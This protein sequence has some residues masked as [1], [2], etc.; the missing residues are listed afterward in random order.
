MTQAD[1]ISAQQAAGPILPHNVDE[2]PVASNQRLHAGWLNKAIIVLCIAYTAFH[3]GVMNLYPLETWTYRLIHV[4]GGLLLGFLI[5]SAVQLPTTAPGQARRNPIAWLLL[6]AGI[7]GI[8]YGFAMIAYAWGAYWMTGNAR[9]PVFVFSS[10]GLPLL[11]GTV[12]ALAAVWFFPSRDRT[13]VDWADYALGLAS[14]AVLGYI[15]FNVGPLRLRA[16]TAMAQPADFYAAL[17]GVIL[18]LEV[19]RRVAGL[20]LVVIASIFILYSFAGPYLPGFLAHRGYDPRRFFTYI[21]TDQGILSDPV[22]VSSTYIILFITFAAFLQASKVGDYFVNFAFAAAGRARGGPAKVAVLASG[23]MGMINGTSAGNVVS[24]GSLTIPLMKKV[25]YPAKTSA[26]IEAAASSGGQIMPPIMGAGA[27]IMAEVTGIPYTDIV[28][29][30]IIPSVLYFASVYFMVDLQATKLGM[31]GLPK[32]E[33]PVF[34]ELLK[35]VYLFIPIIMLIYTLFAG[36]SVIRAGTVSMM[37]A[38]AVSWL[39]PHRMGPRLLAKAFDIAARMSIQLVAVCACAG[40]I[41]GVI[42]LTGVGARFSS[43]LLGIAEQNQ[44]LALFFAM[45]ISIVLGMGMPTTA[46]YAVAAAVVAPGLVNLGIPVLTAHFF[47]FYFAVMSAITPPVA[48]AAYAG[49]ALSGSDPMKTS[50]ESFK[51][52]LAAFVVPFMFFYSQA[53]LMQGTWLEILHVFLTASLGIYML[54]S[55]VQGWFFGRLGVPL[56]LVLLVAALSMI[57]GGL[58]SDLIGLLVGGSLFAYQRRYVTPVVIARGVD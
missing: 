22:A 8:G 44:L 53:M 18:I 49:A 5:Y 13:R 50:V 33:L 10:F 36:Y 26:A 23:L 1:N 31:K 56:R 35:Q 40:I 2:E 34:K 42:A 19:T 47:V 39:T 15:L 43:L 27:F 6:L 14:I 32:E 30:A 41:V 11:A 16:G 17:V 38:A 55:A 25:G 28:I 37:A 9:P 58:I 7:G 45:C 57:S 46:A 3:I 24:T 52:G 21:F 54:A 48:L 51:I 29:A 4:C 12:A 20:A